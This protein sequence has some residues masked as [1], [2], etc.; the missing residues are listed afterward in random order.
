VSVEIRDGDIAVS[1]DTNFG[2]NAWS[3]TVGGRE[4]LWKP[5][6][7]LDAWRANPAL[8]GVPLLA[9]WANRLDQ[10]AFW[11]NGR[12]YL[13]NPGLANLRY[14]ANH[15]PIHGLVLFAREWKIIHQDNAT[16]TSRLDFWRVPEWMAQFPFA[17]SIEVTHRLRGGSLEIETAVENLSADPMPLS[18]GYHPYFQLTD[19]PRD[20]WKLHVAAREQVVLSEKL[21]PTGER[22]PIALPDPYPLATGPLDGVFTGLTGSEFFVEGRRQRI[23]VRFG[24]KYPVAVV[25]AP[26]DRSFVCFEPMTAQTNAFNFPGAELQHIAPGETWRESFWV[27]AVF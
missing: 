17:H 4:I 19:S 21:L 12:K 8:G 14:D 11:A 20:E 18:L 16:V 10:E 2:N 22:T 7:T 3:M 15:L 23:A 24:P 27:T 26:P 25:Y 13:L 5:Q 1:I 9:P 6:P